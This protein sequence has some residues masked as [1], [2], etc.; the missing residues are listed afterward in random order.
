MKNTGRPVELFVLYTSAG[1]S[2]L[3]AVLD[4]LGLL[5]GVPWLK[6]RI[7]TITLLLMSCLVAFVVASV[8][9]RIRGLADSVS[10]IRSRL[11]ADTVHSLS[12]LQEQVDPRID[13]VLGDYIRNLLVTLERVLE[14]RV[15]A[16]HDVDLFYYFW[17]RTLKSIPRATLLYTSLP[18]RRYFW[19]DSSAEEAI[20]DFISKGGKMRRIFFLNGIDEAT[21]EEVKSILSTQCDAGVEVY[22]TDAKRVPAH[23]QKL[24]SADTNRRIGCQVFVGSTQE[25][26]RTEATSDPDTIEGYIRT[27]NDLLDLDGTE[28]YV[29]RG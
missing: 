14:E 28:R 23:L 16:F 22:I 25:I 1:L 20:R 12:R 9:A 24:V 5:S 18:Y 27:F 13:Q 15:V 7:P 10:S 21:T 2:A 29:R 19:K 4:L 11:Q 6:E 26:V 8:S 17:K 3:V